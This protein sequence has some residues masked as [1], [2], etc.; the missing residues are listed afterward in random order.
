MSSEFH[1]CLDDTCGLCN[2]L[3]RLTSGICPHCDGTGIC[4]EH[5][6]VETLTETSQFPI[7]LHFRAT[8]PFGNKD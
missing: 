2:G 7:G 5:G 1:F 4:R 3:G 8:S 6:S